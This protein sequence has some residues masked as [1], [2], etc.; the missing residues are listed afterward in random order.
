[1]TVRPRAAIGMSG[2]GTAGWGP[3]DSPLTTPENMGRFP[4]PCGPVGASPGPYVTAGVNLRGIRLSWRRCPSSHGGAWYGVESARLAA[5]LRGAHQKWEAYGGANGLIPYID[6]AEDK[7][8]TEENS[9]LSY[10][11]LSV[12]PLGKKLSTMVTPLGYRVLSSRAERGQPIDSNVKGRAHAQ[13]AQK[14]Q[15]ACKSQTTAPT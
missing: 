15:C 1:M 11:A 2:Q 9:V 3:L 7:Y 14:S 6:M 10:V 8:A 5:Q 12:G 13:W 4:R